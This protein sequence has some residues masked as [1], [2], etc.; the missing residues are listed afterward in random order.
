MFSQRNNP[1]CDLLQNRDDKFIQIFHLYKL[2]AIKIQRCFIKIMFM[3][4]LCVK[5]CIIKYFPL[6]LKGV[7]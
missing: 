3:H 6:P 4:I 1:Y 2:F 7:L 5:Y